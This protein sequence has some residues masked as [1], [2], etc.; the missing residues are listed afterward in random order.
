M[1]EQFNRLQEVLSDQNSLYKELFFLLHEE[2]ELIKNSSIDQLLENNRKKDEVIL[3]ISSLEEICVNTVEQINNKVPV[4]KR[5][6]TLSQIIRSIKNPRLNTL[7]NTYSDLISLVN[8]VKEINEENKMYI[9]GSLR[10]VQ[11]SISFLVSCAKA[12]TPF[13][14]KGGHL[15]SESLTRSMISEEV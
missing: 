14:E 6:V 13:Y 12:G 11:G 3:Q 8:S 10:A 15:K 7:K 9:N 5:P 1:L 2:K 4:D